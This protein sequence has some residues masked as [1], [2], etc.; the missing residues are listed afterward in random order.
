MAWNH[1]TRVL[2]GCSVMATFALVGCGGSTGTVKGKV[3]LQDK[4]VTSGSVAFHA[5]SNQAATALIQP[6]GSYEAVAVLTGLA[7][8]SVRP[9]VVVPVPKG[10][11]TMDPAKMGAADK[12]KI[13]LP[14][15]GK[16]V[17]IPAKYSDPET[18]EITCPVKSGHN[19]FDIKLP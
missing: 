1:G 6:D 7:K 19:D 11:M 9:T 3:Y 4:L 15:Q 10:A 14:A 18:S 13:D 12:A 2:A 17:P 5:A 8:V 16:V